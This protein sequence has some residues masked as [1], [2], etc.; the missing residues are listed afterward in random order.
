MHQVIY[1]EQVAYIVNSFGQ[2]HLSM[3]MNAVT[4]YLWCSMNPRRVW[5]AWKLVAF[6]YPSPSNIIE[7]NFSCALINWFVHDD[8][9]DHDTGM[10]TVQIEHDRHRQ[11]AI[12]IIDVDSIA[13]GA[14]LL[15]IYGFLRVPDD[16]SHHDALDSFNSFFVN[17]FIDHHTHEFITLT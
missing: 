10:W 1:V 8:E 7:K 15:P 5:K 4:P 11:L 17:H 6:S 9:P 16:F 2:R 3:G 13:W 14:H 12:E